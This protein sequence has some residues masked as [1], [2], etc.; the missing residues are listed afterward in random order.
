MLGLINSLTNL[1][2]LRNPNTGGIPP[3]PPISK[4]LLSSVQAPKIR[5]FSY[6]EVWMTGIQFIIL[7]AIFEY[8]LILLWRKYSKF[9]F[10]RMVQ[11]F[12][13]TS[14]LD[15]DSWTEDE[16]LSLID[17]ISF[18]IALILFISFNIY[19]WLLS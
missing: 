5:G 3:L 10:G 16:K 4:G 7:F 1:R 12:E 9:N 17:I 6:I 14:T 2:Q 8:G 19:Y 13:S 15:R 18:F 11:K